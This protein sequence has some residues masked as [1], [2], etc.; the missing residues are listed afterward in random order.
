MQRQ[1]TAVVRRAMVM[2]LAQRYNRTGFSADAVLTVA[3]VTATA[4]LVS[5]PEAADDVGVSHY[6][7]TLDEQSIQ[8]LRMLQKESTALVWAGHL[9]T[10]RALDA[11]E[12]SPMS[13]TTVRTPDDQARNGPTRVHRARRRHGGVSMVRGDR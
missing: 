12:I 13:W 4:A 5:W 8:L 2:Q 6:A 7:V 1:W 11:A 10:V 9:V 3:D